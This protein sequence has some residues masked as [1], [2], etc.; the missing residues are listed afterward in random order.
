MRCC[1][2]QCNKWSKT[3]NTS[4]FNLEKLS[5]YKVFCEPQTIHCKK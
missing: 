5:G 1:R 4:S 2:W 3:T